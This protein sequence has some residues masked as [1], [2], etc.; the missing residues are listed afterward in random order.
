MEYLLTATALTAQTDRQKFIAVQRIASNKTGMVNHHTKWHQ[1]REAVLDIRTW[2]YFL[3][4]ITL[5]IPNGGLN[6]FYSIIV[7][8]FNFPIKKLTLMNMP[9][10]VIS[11]LASLFWVTVARYSGRPLLCSMGAVIG[12]RLKQ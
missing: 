2:L 10:G 12:E 9:T 1:I 5:N 4:N 3:V 7:A 11:W 8:G 6:G